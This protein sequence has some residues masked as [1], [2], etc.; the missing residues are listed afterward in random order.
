[1]ARP[2]FPNGKFRL[3]PTMVTLVFGGRGFQS[4][5]RRPDLTSCTPHA[6]R[7]CSAVT[8][9][10]STNQRP[11]VAEV[12]QPL[13]PRRYAPHGVPASASLHTAAIR[14]STPGLGLQHSPAL[15]R[16]GRALDRGG[17]GREGG[18]QTRPRGA[19]ASGGSADGAGRGCV[20]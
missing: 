20:P 3:C 6:L 9:P 19:A 7:S 4:F 13:P 1:M 16:P 10:R 5:Q 12:S 8:M 17:V 2:R 14:A 15:P 11:T 18:N